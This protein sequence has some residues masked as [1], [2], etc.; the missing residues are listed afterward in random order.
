MRSIQFG[1]GDVTTLI[2]I[3]EDA[4]VATEL[5][6]HYVKPLED[7]G[8]DVNEIAAHGLLYENNKVKAALG[9]GY[10]RM[11]LPKLEKLPKLKYLIVADTSYFKW[12]TKKTKVTDCYGETFQGELEGY[13]D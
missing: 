2:L 5:F 10:L 13:E 4:V 6:K 1:D 12:I 11:L 8:L 7:K 9:K 3:K